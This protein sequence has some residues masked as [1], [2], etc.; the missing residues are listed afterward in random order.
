[1]RTL[2]LTGYY[3]H[4]NI[5]VDL[6]V[7]IEKREVNP[8]AIREILRENDETLR[9]KCRPV[10]KFDQRLWTLLDDMA[11]TMEKANGVGLAAPQVGIIRRAVVID[12]GE[13][14]VEL[15]NPVI[16]ETSGLC[17]DVEGCLSSPGE[18]GLV[19]RPTYAKVKAQD[20]HGNWI[21]VEGRDLMARAI[22]HELD[23]LDGILFKDKVTEMVD[24][25]DLEFE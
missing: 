15:V 24:P 7:T 4:L 21:E 25:S 3:R 23:H 22:C 2:I 8:M 20:R 18:Y 10:D 12:V 11:Q 9:K 13:G 16:I 17:E 14:L 1:M 6:D 5:V 19:P